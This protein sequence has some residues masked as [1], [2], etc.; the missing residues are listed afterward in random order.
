MNNLDYSSIK[1]LLKKYLYKNMDNNFLE[2]NFKFKGNYTGY[3]VFCQILIVVLNV[4]LL[5]DAYD[6]TL[7]KTMYFIGEKIM[8]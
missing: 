7:H 2:I 3:F 4:F 8:L 5:K 6:I 1:K